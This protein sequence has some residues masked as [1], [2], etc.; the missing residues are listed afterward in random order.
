MSL[1]ILPGG[2]SIDLVLVPGFNS[3]EPASWPIVTY[4]WTNR[5][6]EPKTSTRTFIFHPRL[7]LD[8]EFQWRTLL[9]RGEKLLTCK[10]YRQQDRIRPLMFVAH[11]LG[12]LI[13]KQALIIA[14][15]QHLKYRSFLD[16]LSGIVFLGTPHR[17]E[18]ADDFS[19]RNSRILKCCQPAIPRRLLASLQDTSNLRLNATLFED[20]NLRVDTISVFEQKSSE[21]GKSSTLFKKKK[22]AVLSDEHITTTGLINERKIGLRLS[23]QKIV[24]ILDDLSKPHEE[25]LSMFLQI[26]GNAQENAEARLEYSDSPPDTLDP[27]ASPTSFQD[28]EAAM[29]GTK[30][31]TTLSRGVEQ[32]SAEAEHGSSVVDWELVPLVG[33]LSLQR[34]EATLPCFSVGMHLRNDMFYGR[35]DVLKKIDEVCLPGSFRISSSDVQELKVFALCAMGGLGKTEI[36]IEYAYSRRSQFDAIFWI[37]ADEKS[38]L[39]EDLSHMAVALNIED[40]NEPKNHFANRSI[41]RGWLASPRKLLDVTSDRISQA[42][43]TW[44]L[45]LDNADDPGVLDELKPLFGSGS[46]LITSRNPLSKSA[47]A[48]NVISPVGYDL[49]SFNYNDAAN[50]VLRQAPGNIDGARQIVE[51]LGGIPLSLAH[52]AGII[53]GNYL[54]YKEFLEWYSDETE[55][56]ELHAMSVDLSRST[57][58]GHLAS[59]WAIEKLPADARGL[60]EYLAHLDPDCIQ[61]LIFTNFDI[62]SPPAFDLPQKRREWLLARGGLLRASLIHHNDELGDL[63]IHRLLQ[64]VVRAKI[65]DDR[66]N[67]VL[68]T[69]VTL[70]DEAF[71]KVPLNKRQ[72]TSRWPQ[73][74][75]ILPHIVTVMN[76]FKQKFKRNAIDVSFE[77]A[78]LLSEAG[79]FNTERSEAEMAKPMLLFAL[80]I[81][82]VLHGD[83]VRDLQ[84]DIHYALNA[85]GNETNDIPLCVQHAIQGLELAKKA[86]SETQQSSI[87]LGIAYNQRGVS[88]IITENHDEAIEML[89]QA[90][91]IYEGLPNFELG[92]ISLPLANLGCGHWLRGELE[93]AF[94]TFHR[95]LIERQKLTGKVDDTES[96][97]CGRLL[98]GLGNVRW[99]QSEAVQDDETLKSHL[100]EESEQYHRRALEQYFKTIGKTHHRYADVSHR[101]A[102]HCLR[103]GDGKSALLFVDQALSAWAAASDSYKAERARTSFLKAKILF[104]QGDV[105]NATKLYKLAVRS[106]SR[107]LSG[108]SKDGS[109]LTEEDFDVLVIFWSR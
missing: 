96:F 16:T 47:L 59:I 89:S 90:I 35:D 88:L 26:L 18:N 80:E 94:A 38:K 36:A 91:K 11:S 34:R 22:T 10:S 63:R 108:Q 86:F 44:L 39:E 49:E 23:H 66:Q 40:K 97:R 30:A 12:G 85:A 72:N 84:I 20:V 1:E 87:R 79:W 69:L 107:L 101:L 106:R 75:A 37:R 32:Q 70:L 93:I 55:H 102:K 9:N 52:V 67:Y 8:D 5:P 50:F 4:P 46:V 48:T 61:E 42:E 100:M 99:S 27:R 14:N 7:R 62:P 76:F 53:R 28:D 60:L 83:R 31:N 6:E 3:P 57:A 45:I 58:R 73:C 2:G 81:C 15:Q 95:G 92:M 65:S 82:E 25:L 21:Y 33:D 104:Q 56:S 29:I 109:D 71:P 54:A 105:A 43:A 19:E 64:D 24:N 98:Y 17:L 51:R 78:H 68:H 41:A 103:R 13:V 77:L 74:M